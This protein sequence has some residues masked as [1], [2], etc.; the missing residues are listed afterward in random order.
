MDDALQSQIV[1]QG[2][3]QSEITKTAVT[4]KLKV[5][6]SWNFDPFDTFF[7]RFFIGKVF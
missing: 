2:G 7:A 3:Q 5:E 6:M 1:I 4:F